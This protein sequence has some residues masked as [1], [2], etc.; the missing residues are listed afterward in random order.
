MSHDLRAPLRSLDGFSQAL[1]EDY[2]DRL[3]AQGT[4]YLRR[5]RSARYPPTARSSRSSSSRRSGPGLPGW[6]GPAPGP[7]VLP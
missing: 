2:A 7:I 1:L 5:V 4:D 3:D 6:F